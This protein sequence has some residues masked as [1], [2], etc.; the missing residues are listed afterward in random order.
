MEN[1]Q[2]GTVDIFLIPM[3]DPDGPRPIDDGQGG[4]IIPDEVADEILAM[5]REHFHI[6]STITVEV[7]DAGDGMFARKIRYSTRRIYHNSTQPA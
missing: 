7:V 3:A 2:D 6:E 1:T 5:S 4:L